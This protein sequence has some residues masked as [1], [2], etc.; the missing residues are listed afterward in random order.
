MIDEYPSLL[1]RSLA[2]SSGTTFLG[3]VTHEFSGRRFLCELAGAMIAA[4]FA[5]ADDAQ[6]VV[7]RP[8]ST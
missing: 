3:R 2:T 6:A 4:E 8:A 7:D 1:D 5:P